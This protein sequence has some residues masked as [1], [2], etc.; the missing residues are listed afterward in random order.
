MLKQ[1]MDAGISAFIKKLAGG[2]S[3]Y[4]NHKYKR[5]GTLFEGPFKAKLIDSNDYLLRCASYINLNNKVHKLGHQVAKLH[6][7]SWDEYFGIT[8]KK[9]CAKNIIL[10]QFKSIDEYRVFAEDA[11]KD[12]IENKKSDRDFLDI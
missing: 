1:I 5:C 12:I 11:L 3:C 8:N 9:I 10:N 4:F 2:Y 6:K 7:S